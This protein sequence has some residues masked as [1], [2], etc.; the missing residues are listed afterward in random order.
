MPLPCLRF[1]ARFELP[2]MMMMEDD[3]AMMIMMMIGYKGMLNWRK[4]N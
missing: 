1:V 3:D 4:S 2:M